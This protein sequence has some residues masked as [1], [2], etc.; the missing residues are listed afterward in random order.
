[1]LYR[2]KEGRYVGTS[3][4]EEPTAYIFKVKMEAVGSSKMS[5]PDYQT[6]ESSQEMLV[7]IVTMRTSSLATQIL[8]RQP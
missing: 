5:V 7:F 6:I 4:L 3:I 2:Y 8:W 1:M